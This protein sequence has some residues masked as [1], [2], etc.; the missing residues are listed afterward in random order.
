MRIPPDLAEVMNRIDRT[1]RT[2]HADSYAGLEVDEE[3]AQA[4]VYRVPSASFDAFVRQA[5]G[6]APVVV[7]DAPH[8]HAELAALQERIAE[9]LPYWQ[10]NGVRIFT[11]GA[12][13]DGACVEVGTEDVDLARSVIPQ[14]YGD[15][16]PVNCVLQEPVRR[17]TEH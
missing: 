3:R 7:R 15:D 14:R 4:I 12:R 17:F 13:H 9:D 2:Q 16:A 6:T 1:G 8:S 11:V 10:A 5:A